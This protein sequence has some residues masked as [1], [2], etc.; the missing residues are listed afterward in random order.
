MDL[1]VSQDCLLLDAANQYALN[2]ANCH[3]T[4]EPLCQY[5]P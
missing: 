5:N 1:F 3:Q 4:G 2:D